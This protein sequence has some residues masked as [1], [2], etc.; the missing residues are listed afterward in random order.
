MARKL[1]DD[2]LMDISK[3][4]LLQMVS[5]NSENQANLSRLIITIRSDSRY[6]WPTG[7][8]PWSKERGGTGEPPLDARENFGN[9]FFGGNSNNNDDSTKESLFNPHRQPQN[10]REALRMTEVGSSMITKALEL[11]TL[12]RREKL[13][14][15]SCLSSTVLKLT[16]DLKKTDSAREINS[17]YCET[18]NVIKTQSEEGEGVVSKK[19]KLDGWYM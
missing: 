15:K 6:P 1:R 2:N 5:R 19:I 9:G 16:N 17:K 7:K 12:S 8:A 14:L 18:P 11:S 10:M 3:S 4:R 13:L